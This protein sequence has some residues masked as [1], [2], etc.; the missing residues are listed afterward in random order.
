MGRPPRISREQILGA[1]RAA[2]TRRGFDATTLA[3][4]AATLSVTPAAILRHFPS[5]QDLFTAAMSSR[6][7]ALPPFIEE[8]EN[9][10]ATEDPRVVLRRF[11]EQM[12]PF[13]ANA[14]RPAIAVHMHMAA[15]QTTVVV[16]FDTAAEET[17]PRRGIRILAEY[18]ARAIKAGTIRRADPRAMALLFAGQL[19]AYV[20]NHHVLNVTPVYPLEAYLDAQ[21]ELW[22][23]GA[24]VVGG[25]RAR[26][27]TRTE[28][29][30]GGR[31]SRRRGGGPSVHARAAQTEAARSRRNARGPD[32][33]R[34]VA[35]RRPRHPRP[36]R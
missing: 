9:A 6:G 3:D 7:I 10:D 14:L 17:P 19:Q 34:R 5:K 11:A 4:I 30:P 13:A 21:I 24:F 18:F 28:D 32:G 8:L 15:R 26:K 36:R 31:P 22:V 35:R 29:R 27:K 23:S 20:F 2:F 25:T 33:E 16:P 12:I 1:A